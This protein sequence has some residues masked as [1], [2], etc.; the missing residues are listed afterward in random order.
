MPLLSSSDYTLSSRYDL[1]VVEQGK[2]SVN[3]L[4]QRLANVRN[5]LSGS[6]IA[7]N[8]ASRAVSA[9]L[10]PTLREALQHEQAA[11]VPI[12]NVLEVFNTNIPK[13]RHIVAQLNAPRAQRNRFRDGKSLNTEG[14]TL[15]R[16]M[17][18]ASDSLI[19][20]RVIGNKT[21]EAALAHA[22]ELAQHLENNLS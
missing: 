14:K 15:F 7:L 19:I 5:S 11:K 3:E 10:A 2:D 22:E 4:E 13:L 16:S 17:F 8:N 12:E 20:N 6:T 9:A 21:A 18:D 1:L